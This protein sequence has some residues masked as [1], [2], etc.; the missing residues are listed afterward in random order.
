M[1]K[2]QKTWKKQ[3]QDQTLT[4]GLYLQGLQGGGY[5]RLRPPAIKE[6]GTKGK[7]DSKKEELNLAK[8]R[9]APP[10]L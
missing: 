3:D 6:T 5:F 8:T 4:A 1:K 2:R 9:G 10:T 7:R